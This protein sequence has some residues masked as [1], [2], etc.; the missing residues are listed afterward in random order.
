MPMT[1]AEFQKMIENGPVILD[2]ATGSNLRNAGM[3]VGVCSELWIMENCDAL[4]KLQ[5][6]YVDAG[7]QIVYAP[8]FSA[9]AIS[10]SMYGLEKRMAEMNRTLVEISQRA[11]GGRALVA[12]DLT[13]TGKPIGAE[14]SYEQLFEAYAQQAQVQQAAGVDLFVIET[15][16]GVTE[17]SAAIEAVRSVSRLPIICTLSLDAVGQAWFDG[18]HEQAAESLPLL[19]AN[20]VGVN[21]GQGPEMYEGIVSRMAELTDAPI[22]AKPNAGLPVMQIDG[23]AVYSMSSGRFARSMQKLRQ[24]GAKLLGGCCGTTPEHIRMLAELCG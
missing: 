17:C 13:T 23:S 4:I 16:M 15:M 8:T 20:A 1:Q 22:V 2:G 3:P 18:N 9:N 6:D 7:S 10:L 24:A 11:V 12:G 19:G 14:I 5:R 21:C